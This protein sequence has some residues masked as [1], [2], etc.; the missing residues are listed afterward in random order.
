MRAGIGRRASRRAVVGVLLALIGLAVL[1]AGH[2]PARA[3]VGDYQLVDLGD[4]AQ[5]VHVDNAP[6]ASNLLF[7][8]EQEG[9]VRVLDGGV[10]QPQPFLDIRERVECCGEQGLLSIAFDP[11]YDQNRRF[12]VFYINKD[13]GHD[14][15]VDEF[16]RRKGSELRADETARRKVIVVQHNQADNHNGGQLQFGPEDGNLYI[17]VGDGGTQGDPENDAQRKRSLLGK[18]LRVSPRAKG[19]YDVPH[20]NPFAGKRGKDEIFVRGLRNPFRF[21]FDSQSGALTIGDVGGSDWEEV[22]Y[23]PDGGLGANFGW[24]DFEG[25]HET[26][27]GTGQN[28]ANREPPILEYANGSNGTCAITGGYVIRDPGLPGLA[29]RYIYSDYC[30]GELRTL[31]PAEGGASGDQALGL[32]AGNPSSF[33]EG[34]GGQI[35]VVDLG[36]D[37]FAL[38]PAS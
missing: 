11:D 28:P 7:V 9:I 6:G 10:E 29:G 26:S 5:P 12:Y 35:Y 27:F 15:E 16:K 30:G 36:G 38:E 1:S 33:G 17:S 4:F 23:E 37:V 19:G 32:D 14:L 3:G 25:M 8:V 13:S 2:T 24:N 21:S 18:I 22:D 34:V 31:L 20:D